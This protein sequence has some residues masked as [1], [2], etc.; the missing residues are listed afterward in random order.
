MSKT[1]LA[2]Y[3]KACNVQ[4]QRTEARRIRTRV[5]DA[6]AGT[7]GAASRW[8]FELLQNVHDAGPRAGKERVT[9]SFKWDGKALLF[10]H[11]G[12]PFEL[13]E[14][15][16]L[17]SG[18]SSKEF[19][20]EE[21]TGRFGTGFMVTHALACSIDI[22]F[23]INAGSQLE[24]AEVCLDRHGDDEAIL[25][26]IQASHEAIKSA[27]PLGNIESVPTAQL[28]YSVDRPEA[29]AE[30]FGNLRRT[31]PYLF[32]T[33]PKLGDVVVEDPERH[34]TWTAGPAVLKQEA[35]PH[36]SVRQV[37]TLARDGTA[38]ADVEVCSCKASA[39]SRATLIA[40][41]QDG[42]T[43]PRVQIPEEGFPRLF[44]RF[45]VRDTGTR[46]IPLI[47]DAPFDLPQERDR[48][49]MSDSDKALIDE[50]LAVLP[51]VV[52]Y[53]TQSNWLLAHCLAHIDQVA[54]TGGASQIHE[55]DW[56]NEHLYEVARALS[57]LPIVK[58]TERGLAPAV[59]GANSGVNFHADFVLPRFSLK[60]S[61]G[62]SLDRLWSL[63]IGADNADTPERD[64]ASEWNRIAEAWQRLGVKVNSLGVAELVDSVRGDAETLD[65]LRIRGEPLLWIA[66]LIDLVGE[67]A[68]NHSAVYSKLLERLLPDQSGILRS[69]EAISLDCGIDAPLKALV[70]RIGPRVRSRLLDTGLAEVAKANELRDFDNG[71]GLIV[72]KSLGADDLVADA[73]AHLD[74]HVP[75][76]ARITADTE[77]LLLSARAMLAYLWSTGGAAAADF[78]R[79]LPLRARSG[80]VVRCPKGAVMMG[81]VAEWSVDSRAFADAYPPQRVLDDLYAAAEGR[82]SIGPALAAW[83]LGIASPLIDETPSDLRDA[84]LASV[85]V[86]GQLTSGLAVSNVRFSQ[87]AQLS[88]ELIARAAADQNHAKLLLGL[89]LC[90]IARSDPTWREIQDVTGRRDG[91]DVQCR[92]RRSLW[93]GDLL[94]RA[95]LPAKGE[96]GK[97]I[98]VTASAAAIKPL[99]EPSWL[100]SNDSAIELLTTYFG[101]N[102]LELRITAAAADPAARAKLEEGL[103]ALVQLAGADAGVYAKLAEDLAARKKREE[104]VNRN[105]T[106]GL[107]IQKLVRQCMENRGFELTLID[108]G[109]D[110]D[111]KLP[112]GDP[113]LDGAYRLEIGPW[114]MEV[115]ATT[116]GDV[117]MTPTQ[118][119]RASIE[120]DRYLLCVVDLR[121]TSD[122]E[123]RGPWTT[124]LVEPRAWIFPHVGASV[125]PTWELVTEA[126]DSIVGIRNEKV[127]RYSV[128][129]SIWENGLRL[130]EWVVSLN[131]VDTAK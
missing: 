126:V 114:M 103:A 54:T 73:I 86:D 40:L 101:F 98:S 78:A 18:G 46:P 112:D 48:V 21:I 94:Y 119:E 99:L 52:S 55:A 116:S 50:G 87:I 4:A 84:R 120:A 9:V 30:G 36:L 17:L 34:E 117:R 22:A 7:T 105:R 89:V 19:E 2:L 29:V 59:V 122:E 83:R 69:A 90:H 66:R 100:T 26:N 97:T 129:P 74:K 16:A 47:L 42:D 3:E 28:R 107:A 11:D 104:D 44:A 23:L 113:L 1:A 6:R 60:D 77:P 33:C 70:E 110:Y 91:K 88:S 56:W 72:N 61:D 24:L 43:A 31:L 65:K 106:L 5:H 123:R 14:V 71:L 76:N 8:P 118:A 58:T 82:D 13:Q 108:H 121:N 32:A 125:A 25:A 102:P 111:V 39:Q 80:V 115:K 10:E 51:H 92:V 124:D 45:P 57:E 95:W 130:N 63:V 12:T 127:L 131:G 75:D 53:A 62:P 35:S 81:P 49:L 79:R 15:A 41:V 27:V 37:K 85:V 38:L 20:G 128:P 96:D 93:L 109:Y 67:W 64:I 68:K